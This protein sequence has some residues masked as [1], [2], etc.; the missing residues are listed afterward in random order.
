MSELLG[1]SKS[2]KVHLNVR[3]QDALPTIHGDRV[4]LQQVVMNLLTNASEAIGDHPGLVELRTG[5]TWL[6]TN[7][8]EQRMPGQGLPAGRYRHS[9]GSPAI[10]QAPR[11]G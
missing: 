3:L 11:P 4:Q 9:P 5:E 7:A 2:K 10:D 6:D 1:I 8:I